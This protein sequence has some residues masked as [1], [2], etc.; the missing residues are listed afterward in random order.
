MVAT[1]FLVVWIVASLLFNSSKQRFI[2]TSHFDLQRSLTPLV[3]FCN[4]KSSK[5]CSNAEKYFDFTSFALF[6]RNQMPPF[7]S[8]ESDEDGNDGKNID[9]NDDNHNDDDSFLTLLMPL[10]ITFS[11][12]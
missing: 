5:S 6:C 7:P 12:Y 8:L 4:K 1:L 10:M 11:P 2:C 3:H 9:D